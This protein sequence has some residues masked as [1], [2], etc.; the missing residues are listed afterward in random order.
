MVDDRRG[1]AF[2]GVFAIRELCLRIPL[3]C[4]YGLLLCLPPVL[5]IAGRNVAGRSVERD[6]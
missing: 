3:L 1:R 2:T 6:I 5:D 4:W